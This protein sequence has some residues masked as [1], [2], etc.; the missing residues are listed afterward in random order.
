MNIISSIAERS[1]VAF[2]KLSSY[3]KI[4]RTKLLES[5][6]EEIEALGDELLETASRESNLPIA[7]FQGERARTCGQL[8]MFADLIRLGNWEHL[9]IDTALPDRKPLPKPDIRM[10]KLPIGPIIVFGASNFPWLIQ[11]QVETLLRL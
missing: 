2:K 1:H 4:E 8:R 7:R 11:Q 5:I 6:A 3:T 9:S 10:A